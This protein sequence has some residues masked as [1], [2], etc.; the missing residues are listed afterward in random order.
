M[1]MEDNMFNLNVNL[2]GTIFSGSNKFGDFNWMIQQE[3][4]DNSLFIFNDNEEHHNTNIKGGGN[5]VIRCFNKYSNLDKPRSA[6]VITGTLQ[7]GGYSYF[8]IDI[9]QKITECFD[10]IKYLINKYNYNTIYYSS[11]L[12][13]RIGTSIFNVDTK[14]IDFITFNLHSLT[15]KPIQ[16]IKEIK[17]INKDDFVLEFDLVDDSSDSDNL[18]SSDDS[19]DSNNSDDSDDSNDSDNSESDSSD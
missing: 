12:E 3:E 7:D 9:M 4:F 5:A 1:K 2:I 8:T 11:D 15:R 17:P 10:E 18:D 14:V 6:G 13:G 16:V 19:D